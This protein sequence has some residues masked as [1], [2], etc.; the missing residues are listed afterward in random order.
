M[1]GFAPDPD[2]ATH[3]FHPESRNTIIAT[4][5]FDGG[6]AP[7]GFVPCW[8]DR[9]GVPHPLAD[10]EQ[11]SDVAAY[12]ERISRAVGFDTGFEWRDGVVETRQRCLQRSCF[13]TGMDPGFVP[14]TD[15]GGAEQMRSRPHGHRITLPGRSSR[16]AGAAERVARGNPSPSDP[17]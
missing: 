9:E 7:A 6:L 2:M 12:V 16:S 4:M 1:F 3:P 5:T 13:A 8:I 11:G 14:S 17:S 10:D 15:S